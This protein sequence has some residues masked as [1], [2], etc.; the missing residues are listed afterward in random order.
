MVIKDHC[1]VPMSKKINRGPAKKKTK[2]SPSRTT[3][4]KTKGS[5]SHYGLHLGSAPSYSSRLG[6]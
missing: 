3:I 2:S 6:S 1:R 4:K 5:G